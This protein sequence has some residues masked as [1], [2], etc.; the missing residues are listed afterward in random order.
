MIVQVEV[1]GNPGFNPR[2][3]TI[4]SGDTVKWTCILGIHTVTADNGSFNSGPLNPNDIYGH[5]YLDK[6]EFPYYCKYHGAPGGIGMAG[7]VIVK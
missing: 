1:G 4:K 6:G 3:V 7:L 2:L 5:D